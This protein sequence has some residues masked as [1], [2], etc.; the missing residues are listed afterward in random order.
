VNQEVDCVLELTKF[1]AIPFRMPEKTLC[2]H[3]AP[4]HAVIGAAG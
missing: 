1:S 4:M 2:G 3:V